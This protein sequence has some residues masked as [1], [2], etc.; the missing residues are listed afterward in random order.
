MSV[1]IQKA[2]NGII[3]QFLSDQRIDSLPKDLA[4]F[5]ADAY[6][7]AVKYVIEYASRPVEKVDV[8]KELTDISADL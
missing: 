6:E 2:Q 3:V 7:Q 5:P 8:R 1:L 4:V